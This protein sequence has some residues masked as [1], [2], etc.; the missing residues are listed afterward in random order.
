LLIHSRY[1]Q[2]AGLWEMTLRSRVALASVQQ[3]IASCERD[4]LPETARFLRHLEAG[5]TGAKPM[6]EVGIVAS[7]A[8]AMERIER[9]L[10][11][12]EAAA[13]AGSADHQ[14]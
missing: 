8:A 6:D 9:R 11:A 13:R 10:T 3:R 14:P 5:M 7:M 12:I 1:V 4:G 2:K